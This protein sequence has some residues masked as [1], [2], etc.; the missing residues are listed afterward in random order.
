MN[1]LILQHLNIEPP[2]LIADT[3]KNAGHTLTTIRL[4]Q[5][6][7]LPAT[8]DDVDGILIMGGTQSANDESDYIRAELAWIQGAIKKGIPMLG[9][10]LG[11]QIMARAD[12]ADIFP[13]PVRELGWF[14]VYHTV[15]SSND[16]LFKNMQDGLPV[17][18]WHGES[19]SLTDH[20]TLVAMHPA[21][22]AQAFRLGKAQYGLQFHIE[23]NEAI[24]DSWIAYGTSE[25][26]HLGIE[27]INLLHRET[28]L[29]LES[30]QQFCKQMVSNW[31][32]EIQ[33]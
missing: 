24:I 4:D 25:S 27:G 22:P 21:V 32:K 10:C 5:G 9:I 3:L 19:F 26:E 14:P 8:F 1:F 18:Q 2:A 13:S 23:V 11:A 33:H 20:M 15:E 28:A 7:S 17:F 16:A 6:E 30:M 31:L 29:Y 12:G